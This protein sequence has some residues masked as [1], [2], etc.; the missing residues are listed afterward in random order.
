M[1]NFESAR[2]RAYA[3]AMEHLKNNAAIT[4]TVPVF[5]EVYEEAAALLGSI[6]ESDQTRLVKTQ[7][8][9]AGKQQFREDLIK[10][11]FVISTAVVTYAARNNKQELQE[12]MN[13]NRTELEYA[14]D[15]D[16]GTRTA[17][18]L[19]TANKLNGELQPYGISGE[20]LAGFTEDVSAYHR[21]STKPRN[22]AAERKAAGQAARDQLRRLQQIFDYQLDSLMLQ[23]RDEH[24][25]FYNAY[26]VKRTVVN[27]ARRKTRIEG[28]VTDTTGAAIGNVQISI[29]D[30]QL[31]TISQTDGTYSLKTAAISGAMLQCSKEGYK[32][33]SI[34]I[35]VKRG[36]ALNLPITMEKI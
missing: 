24:P 3:L 2:F 30:S 7:T 31:A 6:S 1:T 28:L 16:L 23:F 18:I 22:Q 14:T 10:K 8:G 12:S 13:F 15:S 17:N 36:Q 4:D 25:G 21:Q 20:M 35:E 26:L 27:P 9:S 5:K 32:P 19:A 11:A 34:P 33:L 29:G